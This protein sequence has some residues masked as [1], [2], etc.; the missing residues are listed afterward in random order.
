MKAELEGKTA[1]VTGAARGGTSLQSWWRGSRSITLLLLMIG[2]NGAGLG[3]ATPPSQLLD[4]SNA[5]I[6]F[7][8]GGTR[9]S[10]TAEF[11]QSEVAQRTGIRLA[12]TQSLPD[13]SVPAI[14][15]GTNPAALPPFNPPTGFPVP[16]KPEGYSIWVD[17]SARSAPTICLIGRDERGAL[18]A[19]GRLL[20]LLN[21]S[22]GYVTLA[23]D[24]RVATAPADG[25][26]AQQIFCSTQS[27]DG[28]VNWRDPAQK[29]QYIRDLIIFGANGFEPRPANDVD[30][31]LEGLGLDLFLVVSCQ[32]IIDADKLSADQIAALL[33]EVVGVDHITTYGGDASGARPP[34]EFFPKMERVVPLILRNHPG[35]K[36][37]YSNQCLDDHAV[38]HDDY[39]FN[40]L[41]SNHPTWLY[42]MVYGPWTKRGIRE[43]RA[44]L[45]AQYALR[46]YPEICHVR[47]CQYPVPQWDQ[48]WA[49][50]WPRNQSLYAMPN[51]MA[52]IHQAT[53]QDTIGFMPYN[54]TGTYND[55]NKFVWNARGWD[56]GAPV[57]E[58]L[59]D[60]AKV[61]FSHGFIKTP[62]G[63][64]QGDAPGAKEKL[65]D[66]GARSVARGLELL[67][68]NWTGPLAQNTSCEAAL[69]LWKD[70]ATSMGG[71]G[72]NWRL[73][74]FLYK[75]FLDAQVKRKYDAEQAFEREAYAALRQA[76]AVGLPQAIANARAALA[77]ID[78]DFQSEEEFKVS[79]QLSRG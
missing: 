39:I 31:F 53:C 54:H 59:Y 76:S 56:P 35:A 77:R 79:V 62:K 55:L 66:A 4:L 15:L 64:F 51:M 3:A 74:L 78:H 36:W 10:H 11:L 63:D 18:F 73:E 2:W 75:A 1:L 16:E 38:D 52:Q 50:V 8:G 72:R 30:R 23:A 69:K 49:Q 43:V 65:I 40:H 42:G 19:A 57:A 70:I 37:W 21:L 71:V 67:E 14:V 27:K 28:F 48:A 68:E 24:A 33:P 26:R 20:R 22:Q 60:Y 25:L 5:V 17:V 6:V 58:I 29:K 32:S 47:W 34:Q 41:Q 13:R 44:A 9:I 46:H 12:I 61:F 45:P 7:A